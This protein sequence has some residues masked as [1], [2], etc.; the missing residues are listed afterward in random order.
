MIKIKQDY[1]YKK[2]AGQDIIIPVGSTAMNTNEMMTL[3]GSGAFIYELFYKGATID[4]VVGKLTETYEI[5]EDTA[6]RDT[7]NF[8]NKLKEFNMIED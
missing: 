6:R 4:E 3:K 2:I 8:V 7:E 5:D 1:M